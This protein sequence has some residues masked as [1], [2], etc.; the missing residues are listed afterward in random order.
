MRTNWSRRVAGAAWCSGFA[1]FSAGP[2]WA[3]STTG[4]RCA[5]LTGGSVGAVYAPGSWDRMG[6]SPWFP[7]FS[8]TLAGNCALETPTV[9]GWI[10]VEANLTYAHYNQEGTLDRGWITASAGLGIGGD[11][12]RIGP[13]AVGLPGLVGAGVTGTWLPG[14]PR[15]GRDGL[16]ARLTGYWLQQPNFQLTVLYVVSTGRL[17]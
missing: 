15:R 5:R 11:V 14:D 2:A 1:L 12:W 10:G 3:Q 4:F 8:P 9:T 13:H 16:E 6:K 17:P 7:S